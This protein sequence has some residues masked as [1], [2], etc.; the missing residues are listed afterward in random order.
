MAYS[1]SEPTIYHIGSKMV[2][3]WGIVA[4]SNDDLY[5]NYAGHVATR[6]GLDRATTSTSAETLCR[7][8]L[9]KNTDNAPIVFQ[10]NATAATQN[11]SV[12]VLIDGTDTATASFVAG[13]TAHATLTITPTTS[14]QPREIL[15]KGLVTSGGTLTLHGVSA[16]VKASAVPTGEQASGYCSTADSGVFVTNNRAINTERLSRLMHAPKYIAKDRPHC[17][18]SCINQEYVRDIEWTTEKESLITVARSWLPVVDTENRKYRYDV[19]LASSHGSTVPELKLSINGQSV[20]ASNISGDG[21]HTGT[22]EEFGKFH[23]GS[24]NHLP[25][26]DIRYLPIEA[27]MRATVVKSDVCLQALQIWREPST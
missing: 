16:W 9:R 8:R 24:M 21:W 5:I 25:G 14:T 1:P 22:F 23:T 19:F 10:L 27:Q 20:T 18:V 26:G 17:L 2:D 6:A 11:G 15:I 7:F 3:N 4:R 13:S 12:I